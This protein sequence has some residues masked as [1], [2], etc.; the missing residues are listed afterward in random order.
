VNGDLI[1]L[2]FAGIAPATIDRLIERHGTP[3][4]VVTAVASG[5]TRLT[6][7]AAEAVR[8]SAD[9]RFEQLSRLGVVFVTRGEDGYPSRLRVFSDAPRWLFLLG[10]VSDAPSIGIV[11]TR[12]CTTYGTDSRDRMERRERARARDR[13][14]GT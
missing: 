6:S 5:R 3:R 11:G 7:R 2:A 13:R 10:E 12:T 14:S 8:V 9:D 1:R 4:R